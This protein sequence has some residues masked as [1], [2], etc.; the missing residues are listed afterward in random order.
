[1][2][3]DWRE[4]SNENDFKQFILYDL[5]RKPVTEILLKIATYSQQCSTA[6]FQTCR[7]T[8]NFLL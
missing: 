8:R 1:M 7:M 2:S 4:V 5:G 6:T 3:I